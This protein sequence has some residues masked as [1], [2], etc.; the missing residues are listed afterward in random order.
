MP[1]AVNFVALAIFLAA[2]GTA[3]A[4]QWETLTLDC[5]VSPAAVLAERDG[6]LEPQKL[7]GVESMR[8]TFT[9]FDGKNKKAIFVGNLGSDQVHFYDVM[10]RAQIIQITP[11]A[12]VTTTTISIDGGN[13]RAVHTRHM[14][15][16]PDGGVYSIFEGPCSQR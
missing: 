12:N 1:N 3:N 9:G 10:G 11:L 14:R 6:R 4:A 8:L 13:A 15:L 2:M 5:T 7:D 16:G